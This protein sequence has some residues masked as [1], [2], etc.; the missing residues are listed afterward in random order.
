MDVEF[1][2]SRELH[3]T[4]E[5]DATRSGNGVIGEAEFDSVGLLFEADRTY[6]RTNQMVPKAS[7]SQ[8]SDRPQDKALDIVL[9]SSSEGTDQRTA[10]RQHPTVIACQIQGGKFRRSG[11]PRAF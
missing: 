8:S 3:V 11:L 6:A 2:F 10:A 5:D 4:T 1:A 7:G 9:W